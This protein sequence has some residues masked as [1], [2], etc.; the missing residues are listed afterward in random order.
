MKIGLFI[1]RRTTC[2]KR[3]ISSW[4]L[5]EICQDNNGGDAI[6]GIFEW[7]WRQKMGYGV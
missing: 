7:A 4:A 2:E 1:K 5:R 3:K 6:R